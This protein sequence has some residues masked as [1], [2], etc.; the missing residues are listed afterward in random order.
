MLKGITYERKKSNNN[1]KYANTEKNNE[2][3]W[4]KEEKTKKKNAYTNEKLELRCKKSLKTIKSCKEVGEKK[5]SAKK[6]EI[7]KIQVKKM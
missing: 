7:Y 6:F 5:K 1:L 4:K 3:L 2:N